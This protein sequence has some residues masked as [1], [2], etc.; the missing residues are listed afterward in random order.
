M[1]K[2]PKKMKQWIVESIIIHNHLKVCDIIMDINDLIKK[3]ENKH[4]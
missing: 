4:T 2:E 3:I 1:G